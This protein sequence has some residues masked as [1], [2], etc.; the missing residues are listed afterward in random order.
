MISQLLSP[1]FV[2]S[3]PS[4]GVES[5]FTFSV[6]P[7]TT[8]Q[9]IL[10]FCTNISQFKVNCTSEAACI[11][12]VPEP[13]PPYA[14]V[15]HWPKNAWVDADDCAPPCKSGRCCKDPNDPAAK[16]ACFGVDVCQQLPGPGALFEGVAPW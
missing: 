15:C 1:S 10:S 7:P 11:A 4:L 8:P 16:G 6:P 12:G 14:V 9:P 2:T 3:K 13:I 5:T